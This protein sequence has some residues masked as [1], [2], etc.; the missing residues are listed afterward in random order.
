MSQKFNAA[1]NSATPRFQFQALV[2]YYIQIQQTI[3]ERHQCKNSY[4]KTRKKYVQ[5]ICNTAQKD[6]SR[7]MRDIE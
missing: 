6:N 4:Y 3:G 2:S 7:N 5:N 1:F